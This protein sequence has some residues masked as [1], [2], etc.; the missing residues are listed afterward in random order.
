MIKVL[1]EFNNRTEY[2]K[3]ILG[4]L[5]DIFEVR[6]GKGVAPLILNIKQTKCYKFY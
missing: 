2:S 3:S 5:F 1:E 4:E 6:G